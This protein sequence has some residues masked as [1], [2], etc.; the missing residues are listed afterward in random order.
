MTVSDNVRRSIIKAVIEGATYN[1]TAAANGVTKNV[2]AGIIFRA[3]PHEPA[4]RISKPKVQNKKQEKPSPPPKAPKPPKVIIKAPPVKIEV[5]PM[6]KFEAQKSAPLL[7]ASGCKFPLWGRGNE[8][9][10]VCN[11]PK[12]MG[13]TSYCQEHYDVCYQPV[14]SKHERSA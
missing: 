5:K 10:L 9:W 3:K 7:E 2:V 1:Q 4:L 13:H 14:R 12:K 11:Q 8:H 6:Q